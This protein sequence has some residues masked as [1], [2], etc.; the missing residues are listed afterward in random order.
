MI[1]QAPLSLVSFTLLKHTG[2]SS[3]GSE[4]GRIRVDVDTT[5]HLRLWL[6]PRSPLPTHIISAVVVSHHESSRKE[7][8]ALKSRQ[9]T[10]TFSTWKIL[11]PFFVTITSLVSSL[12]HSHSSSPPGWWGHPSRYQLIVAL[13][14]WSTLL[15][16]VHCAL[17][18]PATLSTTP[19]S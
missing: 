10:F 3:S 19:E 16:A 12:K 13:H 15:Q 4:V 7:Y 5:G 9:D 17:C 8:L 1:C 6:A 2:P 14:R 11:L 18:A